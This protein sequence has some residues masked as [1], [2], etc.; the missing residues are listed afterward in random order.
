M[1]F[2]STNQLQNAAADLLGHVAAQGFP[3]L[4]LLSASVLC[5]DD[6]VQRSPRRLC[7]RTCRECRYVSGFRICR[8]Y[9]VHCACGT[10]PLIHWD[11]GWSSWRMSNYCQR[12]ASVIAGRQ[13]SGRASGNHRATRQVRKARQGRVMKGES[14][15]TNVSRC[16][17]SF[18]FLFFHFALFKR[19]SVSFSSPTDG[20][21][22][23]EPPATY[24]CAVA[25]QA[26]DTRLTQGDA[27]RIVP[28]VVHCIVGAFSSTCGV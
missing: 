17:S 8:V 15:C 11:D 13:G 19:L 4:D 16:C 2:A 28:A 20:E 14:S 23:E 12:L 25:D 6:C 24:L 1:S 22:I 27:G 18:L 10:K 5:L 9:E 7:C 21:C 26:S 3:S